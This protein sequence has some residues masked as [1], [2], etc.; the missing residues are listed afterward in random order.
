MEPI[1][2]SVPT[3][4]KYGIKKPKTFALNLNVYRN[5]HFQTLNQMKIKFEEAVKSIIDKLPQMTKVK[6]TYTLFFGSNRSVDTSNVCC[7]VDKFF[8]DCLVNAGKLIDD[9]INVISEVSYRFG[10]VDPK[11]PRC[12]VTLSEYE[13]I[14]PK[15]EEPMRIIIVQAEIEE[16]IKAHILN[17]IALK[18]GQEISIDF[19]ATRGDD[20]ATAEINITLPNEQKSTQPV[21]QSRSTAQAVKIPAKTSSATVAPVV[22]AG[23]AIPSETEKSVETASTTTAQTEELEP[24]EEV[25]EDPPLAEEPFSPPSFLKPKPDGNSDEAPVQKPQ[26]NNAGEPATKSLF[27][28]LQRPVNTKPE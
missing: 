13:V 22:T 3:Y 15:E 19:K 6:L 12:E 18:E 28:N 8:S 23:E 27:A 5:T 9:N 20:G 26:A 1:T 4:L 24:V 14:E 21:T 17:Q 10:G 2:V 16:A 25:N 11:N 7:I